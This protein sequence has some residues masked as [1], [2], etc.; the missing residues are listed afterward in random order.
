MKVQKHD[1]IAIVGPTAVG[2]TAY[3]I[4]L[5]NDI[6]GE[7][8]NADAT[9]IYRNLDIGSAKVT[10][11]EMNGIV[12]HLIDIKNPDEEYTVADFQ[13]D[14]RACISDIQSRGKIPI[15]VGGTGLY[16]Q[17][18]LFKYNF[19][20]AFDKDKS[21][22]MSFSDNQLKAEMLVDYPYNPDGIDINNPSRIRNYLIRKETGVKEETN[23][24]EKYYD[25]VKIIGITCDRSVLHERI[26]LRVD[27]MIENGLIDEVRQFNRNWPSQT[28]IGYKEVHEYLNEEIALERAIELIKRNTRRFA[29]RQYTWF[30]NKMEVTW[31]DSMEDK[32]L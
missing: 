26:N 25:N 23:G 11:D 10:N 8:I 27:M 18:V 24:M 22:Y 1:I 30:N 7:I 5:A 14:A 31:Y 15:L 17:A 13:K 3:S 12:H 21:K 28:A 2:K 4:K 29:K 32:W 20:E 19:N 6:D 16:T 9:Q